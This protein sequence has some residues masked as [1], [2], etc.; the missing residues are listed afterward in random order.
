MSICFLV[1]NIGEID[2]TIKRKPV[3]ENWFENRFYLLDLDSSFGR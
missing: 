3:E 2:S 1:K